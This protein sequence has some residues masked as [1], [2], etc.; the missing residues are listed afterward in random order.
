MTAATPLMADR[1]ALANIRFG[2][3]GLITTVVQEAATKDVLMVAWMN[4]ESLRLTIETGRMWYWSRSRGELWC[5]GETSGNRQFVREA[6]Y[7]CDADT[8][9]FV[10]EQEG[11]GACHTGDHTCFHRELAHT[12]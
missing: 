8:L 3:D 9:L 12:S 5:K 7:D 4:S 11:D 10:V 2:A 1:E 6:R